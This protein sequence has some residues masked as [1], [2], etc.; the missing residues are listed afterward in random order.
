MI[1]TRRKYFGARGNLE[2]MPNIRYPRRV[3]WIGWVCNTKEKHDLATRN[4]W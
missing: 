3:T 4:K 2:D 1:K